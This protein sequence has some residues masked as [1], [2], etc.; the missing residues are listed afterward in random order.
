MK[1][2]TSFLL[3]LYCVFNYAQDSQ[4]FDYT[5]YLEKMTIEGEDHFPPQNAELPYIFLTFQQIEDKYTFTSTVCGSFGGIIEF[6]EDTFLFLEFGGTLEEC[7]EQENYDYENLYSEYFYSQNSTEL[8]SY[9]IET[10]GDGSKTLIITNSDGNQAI[11]GNQHLST[12]ETAQNGTIIFPNPVKDKLYIKNSQNEH[13]IIKIADVNGKQLLQQNVNSNEIEIIN[14]SHY[15]R[16]TYFVTI[17]TKNKIIRTEKII[18][19]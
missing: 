13:V 9:T 2:Y 4:L 5:W 18:K 12:Y 16:G 19:D 10:N 7:G 6:N 8:F 15:V 1:L 3:G 17:E 11:Y 14:L